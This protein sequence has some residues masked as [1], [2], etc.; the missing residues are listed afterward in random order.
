MALASLTIQGR[1]QYLLLF[2]S[3]VVKLSPWKK[4]EAAGLLNHILIPV[5]E[6]CDQPGRASLATIPGVSE[7]NFHR[8]RRCIAVVLENYKEEI[9]G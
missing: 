1:R 4:I 3:L 2:E 8:Y 9:R 6:S 5:S 7:E